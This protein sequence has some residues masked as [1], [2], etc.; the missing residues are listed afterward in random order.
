MKEF[1]VEAN[2]YKLM[3]CD[4]HA[5]MMQHTINTPYHV[6]VQA[7]PCT[8]M[9]V[10][11]SRALGLTLMHSRKGRGCRFVGVFVHVI[12]KRVLTQYRFRSLCAIGET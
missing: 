8:C 5:A 6:L 2:C 12:R 10:Y 3:S 7:F 1:G 11:H 4:V 9:R